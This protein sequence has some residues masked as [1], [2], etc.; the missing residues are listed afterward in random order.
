MQRQGVA[1]A[2]ENT[3][4]NADNETLIDKMELGA[5]L[6]VD[7]LGFSGL[8]VCGFPTLL[9][10]YGLGLPGLSF[11]AFLDSPCPNP[12]GPSIQ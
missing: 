10:L 8:T 7:I 5:Q 11:I 4:K 2:V 6:R 12:E 9:W 3:T 1:G